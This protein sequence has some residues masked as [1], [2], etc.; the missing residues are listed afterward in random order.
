[1][2]L[3]RI[4]I[5]GLIAAST[6][7][8]EE[9]T[10][11]GESLIQDELSIVIDS[12]FTATG[13]SVDNEKIQSR[14]IQQLLGRIEAKGYGDFTS[15]FV[16]QFMPALNIDTTGIRADDID[17]LKLV[18]KIASGGYT[19]DSVI[20]MGLNVYRLDRQLPSPIYSDFDPKDYYSE[21]N[22]LGSAIYTATAL[23]VTDTITKQKY[24]TVSVDLPLSL[25]RDMF[26]RYKT[27]PT[28]FASPDAFAE[29]FPG[30]YV[31]N[32]YGAGRVM[33]FTSTDLVMY[34]H[35]DTTYDGRDTTYYYQSSYFATTPEVVTNNN[36]TF[37]IS[38]ELRQMV[39]SGESLIVAPAGYDVEINF[40]SDDIIRNY[41]ANKGS[42]AVINTLSFELAA[43]K[44]TNDY[45]IEPPAYLLMVLK[46]KK[47]EF[48]AKN[49]IADNLTSFLASYNRATGSYSFN[50]MRDYIA[51][52]LTQ[53]SVT[54][55]DMTFI[56]TP[57]TVTTETITSSSYTTSTQ[58]TGIY[59]YVGRPTMVKLLIDDKKTKIKLTYSNQKV[60]M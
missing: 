44:L 3:S 43:E 21:S 20:P 56:L 23:G 37:N 33:D 25:G 19:G 42:L 13:R 28:T 49:D 27:H 32:S 54:A 31:A 22:L 59:P 1:M 5:A 47:D 12:T 57:V 53:E 29:W 58:I 6:T 14:T 35:R 34:Y 36:I 4:L 18:M 8:C 39:T 55:D 51:S 50:S 15:D 10:S 16:T 60:K 2:K 26:N 30:I 52:L 38:P 17:S 48:F 7:A 11:I 40:P 41:R 45:G 24:R 46:S 9:S